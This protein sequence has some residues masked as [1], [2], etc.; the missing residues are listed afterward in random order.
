MVGAP[1]EARPTA[2][3]RFVVFEGIDGAGSSTQL[4]KLAEWLRER[5]VALETTREPAGGPI[6]A[7]LRLA[8]EGRCNLD[9][10]A[11]AL[12]FA[13]DRADHLYNEQDG[14]ESVL[15]AGRWVLCDR[16]VLSSLAYQ[17]GGPVTLEWLHELN[18]HALT[19]DVT[20][21]VDTRAEV[22]A[23]RI[24]RRSSRVELFHDTA[25]LERTRANYRELVEAG[26]ELG[27]LIVVPGDGEPGDVFDALLA[28]FEPWFAGVA[29]A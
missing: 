10:L 20:I 22:A 28:A 24:A 3:G 17:A 16:Y 27:H 29:R 18:R 25:E 14:V 4:A 15:A 13:A 5:G 9:P 11:M 26:Q 19:P 12:A 23:G 6:G 7:V 21:F 1:G 8:I 2:R